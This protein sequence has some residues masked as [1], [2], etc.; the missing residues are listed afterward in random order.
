VIPQKLLQN[1]GAMSHIQQQCSVFIIVD[2][3]ES[4]SVA[5]EL[6]VMEHAW[7]HPQAGVIISRIFIL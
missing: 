3:I 1:H 5:T 4:K 2:L 7:G 6:S